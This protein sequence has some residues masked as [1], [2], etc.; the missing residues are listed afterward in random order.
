M[1]HNNDKYANLD[2]IFLTFFFFVF[3]F[4]LQRTESTTSSTTKG[5][6]SIGKTLLGLTI[7]TGASYGGA[8]YYALEN[9][10]FR[11]TF[12]NFV[13]GATESVTFFEDLK[14]NKDL[15]NYRDQA[16]QYTKQAGDYLSFAKDTATGAYDY[17]VD[18]YSKLTGA[19]EPPR[20]NN[21]NSSS[22][23]T[24]DKKSTTPV[25]TAVIDRPP[26]IVVKRVTSDHAVVRDLSRVVLELASIL[27]DAGLANAG[28]DILTQAEAQLQQLNERY[29]ALD[30]EQ[31]DTLKNLVQLKKQVDTLDKD[32][33]QLHMDTK[34]TLHATHAA[35]ANK[36]KS[37]ETQL[38]TEAE[39]TREQLKQSFSDLLVTELSAQ[40]QQLERERAEALIEQAAELKR[41]FVRDVKLL[42]ER[43]RAGRLAKLDTIHQRFQAIEESSLQNA[44]ALDHARQ[45]HQLYVALTAV[46][47]A[48][49]AHYK[50]PFVDEWEALRQGAQHDDNLKKILSS[51][52]RETTEEGIASLNE[53]SARFDVV[54]EQLRRVALVPE[55]GGFGAHILSYIMSKLLFKKHGLVE[56]DDVEAVLARSSYYLQKSDLENAARELNQLQGWPKKLACGWIQSARQHLEVKQAL[57]IVESHVVLS[58]LVDA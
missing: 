50:Q 54:A 1:T 3:C 40:K 47:D 31:N 17:A 10:D 9:E 43:E 5:S 51:V 32:L 7:V 46:Q 52:S 19:T 22:S 29:Q 42:V 18:T 23:T 55:D 37:K 26:P 27:N 53:L 28:R 44:V 39:E 13:P 38:Q 6:G 21:T 48:V 20:L 41:L 56:G 49:D 12:T 34:E 30:K 4:L 45:T 25:V 2:Y 24:S 15:H 8:V 16:T 11:Q 33:D 14:A 36:V 57:E 35:T 58:S